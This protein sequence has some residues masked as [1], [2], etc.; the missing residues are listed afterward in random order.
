MTICPDVHHSRERAYAGTVTAGNTTTLISD[1][2]AA[3]IGPYTIVS[4]RLTE[5]SGATAAL[6]SNS[7]NLC[8]MASGEGEIASVPV[9][10]YGIAVQATGGSV[11]Y[12]VSVVLG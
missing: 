6:L 9:N 3:K 12:V 5:G 4:A 2:D 8:P 7:V 10:G 11:D 1:A